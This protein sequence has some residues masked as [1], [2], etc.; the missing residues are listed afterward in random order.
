M[1]HERLT[2]ARE[3]LVRA[4]IRPADAAVD[5]ELYARTILKWDRARILL[6]SR[7]SVPEQ[8]EPQFSE[9]IARRQQFEPTAYI[10]GEREFWGLDFLITPA[11]LIPR[12]ETELVVEEVTA[13]AGGL[14]GQPLRIADM[15]TGSGN[16]AVSIAHHLSS[17]PFLMVA[18]DVS[19]AALDVAR[20]NAV[21]HSV[22]DRIEFVCTSWLDGVSGVFDII[23]A[24]PPYVRDID[25]RGLSADVLQEPHV[26]LFGGSTGFDHIEAVLSTAVRMLRPGGWLVMEF[27][28]GQEDDVR[29]RAALQPELRVDHTRDDLQGL[30]RTV[31]I[32]R[33]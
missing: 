7:E 14:D 17:V 31:I 20:R 2:S 24:N 22:A 33:R 4:G 9:W 16:I 26:A 18:T 12:P 5:V 23:A 29:A 30:A 19:E 25:K 15:G 32:Q 1:L 27:G 11:V 21:R 13:I 28:F 10:V 6:N 3:Q 8:L